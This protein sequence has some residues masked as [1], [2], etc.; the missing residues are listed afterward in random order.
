M[1]ELKHVLSGID[2]IIYKVMQNFCDGHSRI[3]V[4][5]RAS[6]SAPQETSEVIISAKSLSGIAANFKSKINCLQ[7]LFISQYERVVRI[8]SV[9]S[10]TGK[11]SLSGKVK[12][13]PYV[14]KIKVFYVKSYHFWICKLEICIW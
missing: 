2:F 11:C 1:S 13:S 3:V 9:S 6:F 14:G 12:N 7:V 5:C 10:S 4:G 8:R